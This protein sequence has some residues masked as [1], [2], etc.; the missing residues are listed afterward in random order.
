MK[1]IDILLYVLLNEKQ[2]HLL[3]YVQKEEIC[4][5][6]KTEKINYY[7]KYKNNLSKEKKLEIV[8]NF[9]E[10]GK[11]GELTDEVDMKIFECLDE[12]LL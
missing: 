4:Y 5:N 3:K 1:D 8:T 12:N 10:E 6:E 7:A 9:I 2:R 11:R